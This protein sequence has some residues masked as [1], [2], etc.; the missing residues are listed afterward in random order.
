[1]FTAKQFR[2]RHIT[3]TLS[4]LTLSACSSLP[5]VQSP[6]IEEQSSSTT[7]QHQSVERTEPKP[8][9]TVTA[10]PSTE[11]LVEMAPEV[12]NSVPVASNKSSPTP[13]N[14]AVTGLLAK[15]QQQQQSGD[16]RSAQTSLQRAQRISPRDPEVYYDLAQIHLDLQD[17]GL[18]EQ[19]AL[20]G[21]SIVQG[22]PQQLK[23]FWLVIAQARSLAGNSAGAKQAQEKVHQY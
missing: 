20:K 4:L 1:M 3:V 7:T 15:A 16:Y 22:Q 19:V 13:Q 9:N 17:Y 12:E 2:L 10:P 11:P 6:V 14:P 21:V 23:K 5:T 8:S 18:A